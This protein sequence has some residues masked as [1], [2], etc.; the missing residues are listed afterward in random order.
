M[1]KLQSG[2]TLIELMIVVAIIAILAAIAI[3]AYNGYISEANLTRVDTAYQE[4]VN[5]VRAEMSR[6]QAIVARGGT[7]PTI[8][9]ALWTAALNTDGGTA[10]DGNP[11]F[12]EGS[13]TGTLAGQVGVT[14][15]GTDGNPV[16]IARPAFDPADDE[17]TA[18]VAQTA[19]IDINGVV[20]Y[21]S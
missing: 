9:P 12:L 15:N 17:N 1:K 3:P 8:T 14:G 5:F 2:F 11:A 13:A 19:T 6:R 4:G 16:V 20:N 18:L 21:G 10:P 7:F